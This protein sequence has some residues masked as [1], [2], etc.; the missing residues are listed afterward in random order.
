MRLYIRDRSRFI[1]FVHTV[2]ELRSFVDDYLYGT[3]VVL[4]DVSV[5]NGQMRS[6]LLK[7]LEDNPMV[8]CYSSVDISDA[9][10]LSRFTEVV[11]EPIVLTTNHSEADF[12]DSDR[13]LQSAVLHLGV[14]D[15]VRLY[16]KGASRFDVSLMCLGARGGSD[17]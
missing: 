12:M 4:G 16:C 17:E 7:F 14:P 15:S 6:M 8:D 2:V 9:V 5:F 11:K 10:L 3:P 1:N 13:S